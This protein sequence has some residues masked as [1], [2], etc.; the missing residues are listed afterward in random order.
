MDTIS[1]F[2]TLQEPSASFSSSFLNITYS[3]DSFSYICSSAIS[4]WFE[5]CWML[6]GVCFW[7]TIS[8]IVFASTTLHLH[9]RLVALE[10]VS[11]KPT[12][13]ISPSHFNRLLAILQ[14]ILLALSTTQTTIQEALD[15]LAH[16]LDALKAQLEEDTSDLRALIA[17][18]DA[19]IAT[20]DET[21]TP[22]LRLHLGVLTSLEHNVNQARILLGAGVDVDGSEAGLDVGDDMET[23]RP[24]EDGGANSELGDDEVVDEPIDVEA[25]DELV[26]EWMGRIAEPL[27]CGDDWA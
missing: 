20:L 27:E 17:S 3:S 21:F 14:R 15:L 13:P 11:A 22:Q 25:S 19:D 12:H 9:R 10:T 7:P 26:L 24:E 5:F 4:S 23:F 2:E 8:V 18:L 6:F 1:T 16:D